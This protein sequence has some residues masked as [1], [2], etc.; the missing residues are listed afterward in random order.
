MGRGSL[1]GSLAGVGVKRSLPEPPFPSPGNGDVETYLPPR[2]GEERKEVHRR[3]SCDQ[4]T[5]RLAM[6][7]ADCMLAGSVGWGVSR[8][9]R[10]QERAALLPPFGPWPV[11]SFLPI[12]KLLSY[13]LV[14]FGSLPRKKAGPR[15]L[16]F[17]P[18]C[19]GFSPKLC[20]AGGRCYAHSRPTTREGR[21]F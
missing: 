16:P 5:R 19:C 9:P 11:C 20:A 13:L 15:L 2:V 12:R 4:P 21:G 3:Y 6:A 18:L 17:T 14:L 1:G 10:R 8:G 7:L